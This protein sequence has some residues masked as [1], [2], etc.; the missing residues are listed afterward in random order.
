ML[1]AV[2]VKPFIHA[3][4]GRRGTEKAL[5]PFSEALVRR[6]GAYRGDRRVTVTAY[7]PR[8]A[9]E[10]ER[11]TA[12]L[13]ELPW[14]LPPAGG[15]LPFF[16]GLMLW[17]VA[18][19]GG[20][21]SSGRVSVRLSALALEIKPDDPV[22]F[23]EH[24]L[25]GLPDVRA[26]RQSVLDARNRACAAE[27]LEVR[28]GQHVAVVPQNLLE[29]AGPM[30]ASLSSCKDPESIKRL[31]TYA[32]RAWR[33]AGD[34]HLVR[35]GPLSP[36]VGETLIVGVT[37]A[38]EGLDRYRIQGLPNRRQLD[39]PAP[40]VRLM[41]AGSGGRPATRLPAVLSEYLPEFA[42]RALTRLL[43]GWRKDETLGLLVNA[44]RDTPIEDLDAALLRSWARELAVL[45]PTSAVHRR[46]IG[47]QRTATAHQSGPGGAGRSVPATLA[48][49]QLVAS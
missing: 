41:Q 49:Y 3:Y 11:L 37:V 14:S 46:A 13:S 15:E 44:A 21:K 38:L 5:N 26:G 33:R 9:A 48:S 39:S 22:T 25:R 8:V 20:L 35:S 4:I 19:S 2:K 34:L 42:A 45:D 32:E 43:A 28:R 31:V 18:K 24:L 23:I 30:P 47:T 40:A 1:P 7:T 10:V 36:V 29:T 16:A 6:C 27:G 12:L 17:E